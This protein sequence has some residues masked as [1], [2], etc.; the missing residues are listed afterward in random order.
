MSVDQEII[1]Q[2][3]LLYLFLNFLSSEMFLIFNSSEAAFHSR[4]SAA[5]T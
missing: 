1:S 3:V 4:E 5:E 2:S